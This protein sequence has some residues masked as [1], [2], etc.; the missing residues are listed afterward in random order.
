MDSCVT[1]LDPY[2]IMY[3]ISDSGAPVELYTTEVVEDNPDPAWKSFTVPVEKL[4]GGRINDAQIL[5]KCFDSDPGKSDDFIG[6]AMV[7]LK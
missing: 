6:S 4:T 1:V 5:F 3:R 2:V 7:L